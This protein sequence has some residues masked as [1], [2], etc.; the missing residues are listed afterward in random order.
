MT[1]AARQQGCRT[2]VPLPQLGLPG[3]AACDSRTSSSTSR[4]LSVGPGSRRRK[5]GMPPAARTHKQQRRLMAAECRRD[6]SYLTWAC[7]DAAGRKGAAD[8]LAQSAWRNRQW[9][10][11]PLALPAGGPV[12]VGKPVPRP[13]RVELWSIISCMRRV[14]ACTGTPAGTARPQIQHAFRG[15]GRRACGCALVARHESRARPCTY[16]HAFPC[17]Q[18]PARRTAAG[19]RAAVVGLPRWAGRTPCSM[20]A[21]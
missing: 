10:R 6:V 5:P 1:R 15:Q 14:S 3:C 8:G 12:S 11:C 2:R 13:S 20:G 16:E 9:P 7:Q 4:S 21:Y 17:P 18:G 19:Q